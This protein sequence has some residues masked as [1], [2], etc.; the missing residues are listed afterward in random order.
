M[1]SCRKQPCVI[2]C[3][4]REASCSIWAE[5]EAVSGCFC[6]PCWTPY[7]FLVIHGSGGKAFSQGYLRK[8]G[9]W[10]LVELPSPFSS[11]FLQNLQPALEAFPMC[12]QAVGECTGTPW[13]SCGSP[14]REM[15]PRQHRRSSHSASQAAPLPD[16]S[17]WAHS[18]L[19][20][21]ANELCHLPW[22]FEG[23]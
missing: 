4:Q 10:S 5:S 23:S 7:S 17:P 22:H 18:D 19:G 11:S 21:C 2:R 1:K 16:P 3:S 14:S 8:R 9:G 12:E 13:I 20:C 6:M 15:V